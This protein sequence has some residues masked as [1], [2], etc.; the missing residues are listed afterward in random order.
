M[1]A[2][3]LGCETIT[4][5]IHTKGVDS[6]TQTT[7]TVGGAPLK[8]A[9]SDNG[10]EVEHIT[11]HAIPD[12]LPP[13]LERLSEFD[14]LIISDV[15]ANSFQLGPTKRSA[16]LDVDRLALI[17][18]YVQS[19]GALLMIGGYMAFS[20]VNGAA[21]FGASALGRALPVQL[22]GHDDRVEAPAGATPV[23]VD[24]RHPI[25][26][27]LPAM[28]PPVLGYNKV[29][30]TV[31]SHVIVTAGTDP[32]LAV[33]TYGRGRVATFMTDFGPHWATAEFIS[34][35]NYPVLWH[36]IASWAVAEL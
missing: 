2:L 8:A 35:E 1:Q 16:E 36:R 31:A 3:L 30:P 26:A 5:S 22:L 10:W 23:V 9:L 28:W 25:V 13:T 6:F 29:L 12:E 15:G 20:G 32:L 27:G 14:L 34:W 7:R 17:A 33:G 18:E 19:G 11:S 21:G 4:H 24:S